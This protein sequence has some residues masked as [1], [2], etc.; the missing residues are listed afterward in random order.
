MESHQLA[1]VAAA[2][3]EG[4]PIDWTSV[5]SSAST[6]AEREIIAQLRVLARIEAVARTA[7]SEEPPVAAGV[8]AAGVAAGHTTNPDEA[9]TT[10]APAGLRPSSWRHLTLDEA[11]GRGGF[12]IVYRA[13]DPKLDK[14]VALKLIPAAASPAREAEVL[15]E[16]RRLARVRHPNVVT[17]HGAD[18]ENGYFGLWMEFVRGR[19]LRQIVEQRGPFGSD[20]ALLIGIEVARAL[21]AVHA[22][23]LIHRDIKAQNVMREDGGRLVLMDFGA[24]DD[25][26]GI[27]SRPGTAG[28]PVYMAPEVLNGGGATPQSDIYSLGV[29]LF[30]LVTGKHPVS[31]NTWTEAREAHRTGRRTLLRD[32]RPD[33]PGGFVQCVEMLI[34]PSAGDRVQTAGAAEALLQQTLVTRP[35]RWIWAGMAAALT[36]ALLVGTG[37]D[38][39]RAWFGGNPP[40]RSVAVLPMTNLSGDT[41]RDYFVDGLTDQVIAE[42]SRLGALRVTDWTSVM[43]YKETRKRLSEIAIELG[44]EAVLESSVVLAGSDMRLTASLIRASDGLRLGRSRTSA[45]SGMP[46]PCRPRWLVTWRPASSE[47]SIRTRA[48]RQPRL[49]CQVRRRSISI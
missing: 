5:E 21:A 16:G 30:Y 47:R 34:A 29:L 38:T 10:E 7:L 18:Y 48:R 1:E 20:E 3:A 17:I 2:I 26:R 36:L 43:G 33:L 11:V 31:G 6:P 8:S 25:M 24:G 14:V 46:S 12:G 44:V 15:G 42:L 9:K 39:W 40:L 27:A 45:R 32:L 37:F 28:T 49:T 4:T 41:S 19:T 13:V 35:R 23:G 22:A